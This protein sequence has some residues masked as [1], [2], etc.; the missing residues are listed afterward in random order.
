MEERRGWQ[1]RIHAQL[2]H[3]GCAP[4]RAL[5]STAGSD[6]LARAELSA[7][8]RRYGDTALACIT[9]DPNKAGRKSTSLSSTP[10][11][12]MF[13]FEVKPSGGPSLN[14]AK[15]LQRLR[16]AVGDR[17]IGGAVLL[18]GPRLYPLTERIVAAPICSTVGMTIAVAGYALPPA[19][20]IRFGPTRPLGYELGVN[21]FRCSADLKSAGQRRSGVPAVAP[22]CTDLR[23][24]HGVLFPNLV[25]K[26]HGCPMESAA[27]SMAIRSGSISFECR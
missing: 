14:D 27:W 15:H 20:I 16:D 19:D 23:Q 13:G 21:G 18:S 2:S 8:G 22:C 3:Q 1:Q 5:L 12:G 24:F 7:A 17:F 11:G 25:P 6:A 10:G 26:V 9:C 4:I